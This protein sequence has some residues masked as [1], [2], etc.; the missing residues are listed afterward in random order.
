MLRRAIKSPVARFSVYNGGNALK[1]KDVTPSK[2][3]LRAQDYE[4]LHSPTATSTTA[5]EAPLIVSYQGH[6]VP[7]ESS[8]HQVLA[9]APRTLADDRR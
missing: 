2:L 9:K 3:N 5:D 4:V 1:V 8:W 6:P 7:G